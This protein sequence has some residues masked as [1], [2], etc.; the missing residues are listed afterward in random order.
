MNTAPKAPF[1]GRI[2]PLALTLLIT[3]PPLLLF[4]NPRTRRR[5]VA[6]ALSLGWITGGYKMA[7][8]DHFF[9]HTRVSMQ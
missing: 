6:A 4:H 3:A 5:V 7:I 1:P 8:G 9:S 2:L